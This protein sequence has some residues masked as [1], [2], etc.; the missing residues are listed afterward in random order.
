MALNNNRVYRGYL[1]R[2][3]GTEINNLGDVQFAA[4]SQQV[5]LMALGDIGMGFIATESV[6]PTVS[7]STRDAATVLA[8]ADPTS[9]EMG[10]VVTQNATFQFQQKGA[11][12]SAHMIANSPKGLLLVNDFGCEQRDQQALVVN[13]VYHALTDGTNRPLV[14]SGATTLTGVPTVAQAFR[15]GPIVWQGTTLAGVTSARI[16][17]GIK[18]SLPPYNGAFPTDIVVDE[19]AFSVSIGLTQLEAFQDIQIGQTVR[20]GSA[21]DV[22]FQALPNGG[23]PTAYS[24]PAHIKVTFPMGVFRIDDTR[25]QGTANANL[26]VILESVDTT[27]GRSLKPTITLNS[28]ITA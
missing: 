1:A 10:R 23:I 5:R 9:A 7:L 6:A 20:L 21:V 22:Y 11:S 16:Q 17:T 3:D 8:F 25:A 19:H 26:N 4:N 2:F 28:T 13:C 24:T 18:T 14:P 27:N 15:L 12:A